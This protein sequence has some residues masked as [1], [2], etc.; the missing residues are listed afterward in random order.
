MIKIDT[1]N[2]VVELTAE[3]YEQ[4]FGA[5]PEISEKEQPTDS[6]RIEALEAAV[7]ELAVM[8]TAKEADNNA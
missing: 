2:G 5:L 7:G 1:E 4:Q 6:Q 3:E 8:V